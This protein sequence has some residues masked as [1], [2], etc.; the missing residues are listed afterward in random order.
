MKFKDLMYV[1][2]NITNAT[3]GN[4][5]VQK[6]FPP[7]GLSYRNAADFRITPLA[8]HRC[9]I[10]LATECAKLIMFR[11]LLQQ[12]VH[13]LFKGLVSFIVLVFFLL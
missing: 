13:T 4:A 5:P 9:A 7:L 6:S 1:L 11:L 10:C 12:L 8:V 2:I 3:S